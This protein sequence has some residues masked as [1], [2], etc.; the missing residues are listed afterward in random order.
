MKLSSD[1]LREAMEKMGETSNRKA[2]EKLGIHGNTIGQYL[3]GERI[4]DDFACIM[5]AK[6]LG[7]DGMIVIAAAQM[8][9]EKNQARKDVW[10]DLLK[11]M[12]A[13]ALGGLTAGA[14]LMGSL[15]ANN[16]SASQRMTN[17]ACGVAATCHLYIMSNNEYS[18][19]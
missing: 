12:G 7:I 13:L 9:R 16:A 10:E 11:K 4:M 8:E 3:S 17:A 5:V 18:S 1:Y 2:G 14:M 15:S 19:I 6:I